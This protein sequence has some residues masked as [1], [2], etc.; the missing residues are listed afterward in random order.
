MERVA[1]G[2]TLAEAPV[3]DPEDGSVLVSDAIDGGLWRVSE[4]RNIVNAVPHRRGIGG[5]ALHAEGGVIVSGRNVAHKR[6]GGTT[7]ILSQD[8]H[9]GFT[10]FNDLTT[11]SSGRIYVGLVDMPLDR[12]ARAS[13]PGIVF[14]IDTDG[15]ARVVAEEVEGPNGMAFT[16][17]G[18]SFVL[19]DTFA[20]VVW[21]YGVDTRGD[22]GKR[23][24]WAD[25]PGDGPDGL[26]MA[27]DGSAW[28][29]L[30]GGSAVVCVDP[31]GREITR[32]ATPT[33]ATSVCF[34]GDDLRT[35]FVT[36]GDTRPHTRA[37]AVFRR[38]VDTPGLPVTSATVTVGDVPPRRGRG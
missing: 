38:R 33:P 12:T 23:R 18:E 15:C 35:L 8:G 20:D 1:G 28:I 21:R 31:D 25:F 22:L 32:V 2:F 36:T 10:H 30:H 13:R 37:G 9:P 11:D 19:S 6:D 34:G 7:V 17:D 5:A 16:P 26:A 27:V 4:E 3:F 29:A 14:C 24:A